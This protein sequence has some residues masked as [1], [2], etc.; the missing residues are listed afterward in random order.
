MGAKYKLSESGGNAI[1]SLLLRVVKM[2]F[3]NTILALVAFFVLGK[4]EGKLFLI[5]EAINVGIALIYYMM[6][7]EVTEVIFEPDQVVVKGRRLLFLTFT[8]TSGYAKVRYRFKKSTERNK[9]NALA[10]R[11]PSLTLYKSKDRWVE[12][13]PGISGWKRG[14]LA[15]VVKELIARGC[16]NWFDFHKK[17]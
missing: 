14:V 7:R 8:Y 5:V 17:R 15:D 3:I 4:L 2:V 11:N 12:F 9:K 16:Y 6:K 13:T 10:L 1:A